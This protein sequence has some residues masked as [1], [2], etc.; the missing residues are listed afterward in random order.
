MASLSQWVAG[1]RPRTLP[2]AV[3]PVVLGTAAA[4]LIGAA[5]LAL[6]MLALLV[7]L[8]LQVGVNYAND[9][10]D[11]I[12]GTDQARVGPVRLVGQRLA[13][14][15]TV[16]LAA[17]LSFAVAGL[18][19]LTLVAL[20]GAWVMVPLGA[21]AVLA[22]WRYTGGENPYGYRGLGELYVFVFFGLLA[23][24]GTLYTQAAELTWFALLGAVGVGA[25]ASAILV[26]NNLRDIPT[27]AE[28]GKRT[29]AVRLGDR[30]TRLLYAGLVAASLVALVGMAFW[31][32]WVL[33][34][35]LAAPLGVRAVRTVLGG[36]GGRDL[37]PVLA[38]T[39]LYE[40]AYAV[41]VA[42]GV[43]IGVARA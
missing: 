38:T 27:D 2:A 30:R 4:H 13:A 29:L 8:S 43:I 41:L 19:G 28:H 22:A 39:G 7:A 6:A 40:V 23:T 9:Y 16:R 12:R 26:A 17:F 24:L 35:L 42:V 15:T 33:L 10:S 31:E 36:A 32:P 1:A 18:V 14:P 5:D 37:V 20:S 11:G 21:L 3:A 34:G 25:V